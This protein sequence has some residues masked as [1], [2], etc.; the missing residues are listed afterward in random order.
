MRPLVALC[1]LAAAAA[2][3]DIAVPAHLREGLTG[4]ERVVINGLMRVR[5]GAPVEP[6]EIDLPPVAE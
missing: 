4:A 2:Q 6:K 1:A 3:A 5:P